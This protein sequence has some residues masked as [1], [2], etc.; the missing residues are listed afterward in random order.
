MYSGKPKAIRWYDDGVQLTS[1]SL[2]QCQE[3]VSLLTY[4]HRNIKI[5][6]ASPD[7][8][9]DLLP[10]LLQHE[11]VK[12]L[13]IQDTQLTQDCISSLCNL[14]ANN[15][16]LLYLSLIKC[17]IDDKAVADITNVLQTHNNTLL[18]LYFGNNPLISLVSALSLSE[19][20]INNSTL[21]VLQISHT[22]ISSDGILLILQS[23]LINKNIKLILDMKHKDTCTEYHEY[24]IIKNRVLFYD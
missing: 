3:V 23:L 6:E 22:S 4:K 7:V 14:L 20:I 19:L 16:S 9:C 11:K 15:K 21:A 18:G 8:V 12:H 24:N 5:V 17:S 2:I 1:P 10:V 13:T